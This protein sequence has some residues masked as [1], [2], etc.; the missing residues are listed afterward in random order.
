MPQFGPAIGK[1]DAMWRAL[2]IARGDLVAYLDSDTADFGRHFVYGLLGPLLADRAVRFA[3]ATYSRP[4]RTA[5]GEFVDDAGRVTELTA[6]PLFNC[7]LP[8][9]VRVRPAAVGRDDRHARAALLDSVLHRLRGR[10]GDDDRRAARRRPR[11][12]GPGR[13]GH[14]AQ[15]QPAAVRARHDGLRGCA[16]GVDAGRGRGRGTPSATSIPTATCT[17]T[18]P[19]TACGSR[20]GWCGSSSDRRWQQLDGGAA[21]ERD[22]PALRLHDID[23]TMLGRGGSLLRDAEG[24]FSTLAVRALEACDRAGVEVVL[25]SGRRKPQVAEDSRL[26]GQHS[27]IYEMGCGLVDGE[28][29]LLFTDPFPTDGEHVGARSDRGSRVRSRCCS[30]ASRAGSSTTRPGTTSASTR[31][32]FAAA[33]ISTQRT[34]CWPSTGTPACD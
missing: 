31:T 18:A 14:E 22:G 11:R 5:G 13:A 16:R 32:C 10:D 26:I 8:R 33:S 1:G 30:R 7:L 9:A 20:S 25:K 12:D 4:F 27:Y 24:N 28:E 21:A 23:G 34:R 15:S 17:P 2:S 3:K 6:K 29:E 19:R